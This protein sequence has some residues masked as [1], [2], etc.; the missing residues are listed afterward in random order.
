MPKTSATIPAPVVP[1]ENPVVRYSRPTAIPMMPK[2]ISRTPPSFFTKSS[3]PL[4]VFAAMTNFLLW[5]LF[6][7]TPP[8][9]PEN[10]YLPLSVLLACRVH[11]ITARNLPR[12]PMVGSRTCAVQKNA[13]QIIAVAR[14][15]APNTEGVLR[16]GKDHGSDLA[17]AGRMGSRS[18]ALYGADTVSAACER[19]RAIRHACG[20]HAHDLHGEESAPTLRDCSSFPGRGRSNLAFSARNILRCVK[21]TSDGSRYRA[22]FGLRKTARLLLHLLGLLG[23]F[24]GRLGSLCLLRFFCHVFLV[25][26]VG[27]TNVRTLQ[28]SARHQANTKLAKTIPR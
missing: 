14:I 25:G 12:M 23:D 19:S 4:A 7:L 2:R 26:L 11:S 20:R 9:A 10:R 8:R 15:G 16:S 13:K 18:A 24:L 6:R 1:A 22:G 3:A 5:C 17:G 27:L 21:L 28:T